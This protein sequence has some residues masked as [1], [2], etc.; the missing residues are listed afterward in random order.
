[1]KEE[2]ERERERSIRE[3]RKEGREGGRKKDCEYMIYLID[4]C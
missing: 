4:K 2:G 1:M 3:K